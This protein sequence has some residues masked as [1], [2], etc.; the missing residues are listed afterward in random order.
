[1]TNIYQHKTVS[2]NSEHFQDK[3]H[4]KNRQFLR[5]CS[6]VKWN[7]LY[8]IISID[9]SIWHPEGG[10]AELILVLVAPVRMEKHP[11][12]RSLCSSQNTL[13][14]KK[15]SKKPNCS[16]DRSRL[17]C[18][19]MGGDDGWVAGPV[20]GLKSNSQAKRRSQYIFAPKACFQ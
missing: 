17:A 20:L 11:D 15:E 10:V 19:L 12:L 5:N 7:T 16:R 14:I 1:M 13:M 4:H 8:P 2:T 18:A 6:V 9:H 3:P